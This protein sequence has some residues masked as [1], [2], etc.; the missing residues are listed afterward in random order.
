MAK[1]RKKIDWQAIIKKANVFHRRAQ[2]LET[3]NIKKKNNFKRWSVSLSRMMPSFLK[4]PLQPMVLFLLGAFLMLLLTFIV[5]LVSFAMTISELETVK[6]PNLENE[7]LADAIIQL[8]ERGL[9]PIIQ[10]RYFSDP[11]SAGRVM[12]QHP[13]LGAVVREGRKINLIVSKGIVVDTLHDYRQRKLNDVRLEIQGLFSTFDKKILRIGAVSYIF[14]EAEPETILEQAPQPGTAITGQMDVSFVVSRG[15]K[16]QQQTIGDYLDLSFQEAIS[17]LARHNA[18]FQFLLAKKNVDNSNKQLGGMVVL[19]NPAPTA[20]LQPDTTIQLTITEPVEEGKYFGL[21]TVEL[22]PMY[23]PVDIRL[24]AIHPDKTK[25][26]VFS[27]KSMGGVFIIPYFEP[28]NT[29]LVF[30]QLDT[31]IKKKIIHSK[32]AE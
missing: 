23:V 14:N 15:A 3:D 31:E 29:E 12:A 19:Q 10:L 1:Y 21:L 30:Y 20:V 22:P 28:E 7:L 11:L 24:V 27:M 32:R 4:S 2:K 8:Q 17:R 9:T 26:I 13:G 6:V 16:A 18:T 25:R 5:G